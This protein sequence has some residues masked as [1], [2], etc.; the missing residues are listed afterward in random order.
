MYNSNYPPPPPSQQQQRSQAQQ[1]PP[2][3]MQVQ[4]PQQQQQHPPQHVTNATSNNP[5]SA[6]W[7]LGSTDGSFALSFVLALQQQSV[8]TNNST[9]VTEAMTPPSSPSPPPQTTPSPTST[10]TSP[11]TNNNN[12][13]NNNDGVDG[14]T[15]APDS[16]Q[17]SG[18]PRAVAVQTTTT[19]TTATGTTASQTNNT[20]NNSNASNTIATASNDTLLFAGLTAS[21]AV[22]IL[23]AKKSLY[24]N[25]LFRQPSSSTE[26]V[27][28]AAC[29]VMGFDISEMWLRTGAKTHLLTNTH[30]RPTAL[31]DSARE[32]LVDV[33]YGL[34]SS[35]RT[36]RLSPALCKRAKKASDVVWVSAN[37][38]AGK[39]ALRC[40]ISNVR[41]AVAIPICHE[42]SNTNITVIF[43]SIRK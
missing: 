33:Y 3:P 38:T 36:H 24:Q 9:N 1:H 21:A 8:A 15:I 34:K 10:S 37:T 35:E 28:A 17:A 14:A 42:T 11:A 27:L 23:V 13:N 5:M 12:N 22:P 39:E 32:D 20:D 40:S 6:P 4:L 2:I 30:L 16:G 41:T 26:A 29:E 7:T 18:I 19:T 25:L 31:E 43:F